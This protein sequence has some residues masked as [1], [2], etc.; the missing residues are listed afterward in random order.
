M[1]NIIIQ[2]CGDPVYHQIFSVLFFQSHE[3]FKLCTF[4]STFI[5]QKKKGTYHPFITMIAHQKIANLVPC[6]IT[7]DEYLSTIDDYLRCTINK[8][9][10]KINLYIAFGTIAA[11]LKTIERMMLYIEWFGFFIGNMGDTEPR[12]IELYPLRPVAY[13]NRSVADGHNWAL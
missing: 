9:F 1:L 10:G 2:K 5:R 11:L 12:R 6:T 8:G 13:E 3:L 4:G 7:A